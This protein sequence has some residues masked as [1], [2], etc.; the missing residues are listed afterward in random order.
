MARTRSVWHQVGGASMRAPSHASGERSESATLRRTILR[1]TRWG[2][3]GCIGATA[4]PTARRGSRD[5]AA[6]V[7]WSVFVRE[8][9]GTAFVSLN[10]RSAKERS[11]CIERLG[12]GHQAT[13]LQ[14]RRRGRKHVCRRSGDGP[15]T[16]KTAM[17]TSQERGVKSEF[18]RSAIFLN[19]GACRSVI[20]SEA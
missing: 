8:V 3:E 17:I 14:L 10:S 16:S 12:S 2:H 13:V 15:P 20:C 5:I 7:F 18:T 4:A 19:S 1:M 9:S 6:R 11:R